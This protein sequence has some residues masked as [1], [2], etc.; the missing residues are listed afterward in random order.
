MGNQTSRQPGLMQPGKSDTKA[1]WLDPTREFKEEEK[2]LEDYL[3]DGK[4]PLRALE[5]PRLL[6][7]GT[8]S[9]INAQPRNAEYLFP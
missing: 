6:R 5:N 3:T 4:A 9:S 7:H 2:V 8:S 1:V